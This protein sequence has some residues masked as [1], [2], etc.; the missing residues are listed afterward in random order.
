[1]ISWFSLLFLQEQV[2]GKSDGVDVS[3]SPLTLTHVHDG[4][5]TLPWP[6]KFASFSISRGAMKEGLLL[7]QFGEEAVEAQRGS[8]T[9]AGHRAGKVAVMRFDLSWY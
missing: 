2:H 8:V 4:L 6:L 9:A 5:D 7:F 3:L 1:M